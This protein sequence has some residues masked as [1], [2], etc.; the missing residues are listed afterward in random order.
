MLQS[1]AARFCV[2]LSVVIVVG[3]WLPARNA[4]Q[5]ANGIQLEIPALTRSG[6]RAPGLPQGDWFQ[7]PQSLR[8]QLKQVPASLQTFEVNDDSFGGAAETM[9]GLP[10]LTAYGL[11]V[12]TP[13]ERVIA[14]TTPDRFSEINFILAAAPHTIGDAVRV[15]LQN[16]MRQQELLRAVAEREGFR[17]IS[18][19]QEAQVFIDN[20]Y[21]LGP[22]LHPNALIPFVESA[23]A[24][25]QRTGLLTISLAARSPLRLNCQQLGITLERNTSAGFSSIVMTDVV[26]Q[27]NKV[28]EQEGRVD[29]GKNTVGLIGHMLSDDDAA[30]P[31]E[32]RQGK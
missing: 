9:G 3:W 13:S 22:S 26:V 10:N 24:R 31:C 17:L 25:G 29:I 32:F 18:L 4:S 27:R 7:L 16:G 20:R 11:T 30:A 21:A 19:H 5:A 1:S 14:Q 6:K 28:S 15:Y 2:I 23:A 8:L 12:S